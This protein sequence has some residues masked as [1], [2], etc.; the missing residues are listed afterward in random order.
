[1]KK[2]ISFILICSILLA[3][4]TG[5][6]YF[7]KTND[8]GNETGDIEVGN[9]NS[10]D[11]AD[12]G[13]T[14]G[15]TDGTD[16]VTSG[17]ETDE[18]SKGV[19][20]SKESD[21]IKSLIEIL[22][23]EVPDVLLG[24]TGLPNQIYFVQHYDAQPLEVTFDPLDYY[25]VCGYYN[26]EADEKGKTYQRAEKCSWYRF[27]SA[28]D[29]PE[30]I[31][32]EKCVLTYQFNKA[33]S[34]INLLGDENTPEMEHVLWLDKQFENGYNTTPP[35]AFAKTVIYLQGYFADDLNKSTIYYTTRSIYHNYITIRFVELSGM[36]YVVVPR[37][38]YN[39]EL[40]SLESLLGPY[41]DVFMSVTEANNFEYEG[42]LSDNATFIYT[43]IAMEHFIEVLKEVAP[44]K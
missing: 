18:A 13:N 15:T 32:G 26:E 37:Y 39:G 44:Q 5:C 11:S 20:L 38:V 23:R 22:S 21:P 35:I 7:D 1:M 16:N 41:Y 9:N 2:I 4:L 43:L 29:I 31:N 36:K 17:G 27:D 34:V 10:N 12:G 40:V 25:F 28:E 19:P 14:G 3:L 6:S 33:S 24:S 42:Y 8:G 30:Y